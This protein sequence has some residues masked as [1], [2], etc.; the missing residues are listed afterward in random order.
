ML[1]IPFYIKSPRLTHALLW[2]S[3]LICVSI[4]IDSFLVPGKTTKEIVQELNRGRTSFGKN[5]GTAYSVTTNHS[6]I[7]IPETLYW[8]LNPYDV[9]EVE[10]SF[11][12]GAQKSLV[13]YEDNRVY[14]LGLDYIQNGFGKFLMLGILIA[15]STLSFFFKRI[16]NQHGRSN[17]CIALLAATGFL[18]LQYLDIP[19]L[20]D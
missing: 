17:L 2:V 3:W 10:R 1:N 14:T 11:I 13:V 4:A 8:K 7:L 19:F 15:G 6:W 12:T 16:S 5:S 9:V 18:M 20:I